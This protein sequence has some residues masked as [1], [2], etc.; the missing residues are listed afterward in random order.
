M[1]LTACIFSTDVSVT[2]AQNINQ[3]RQWLNK[4]VRK[5]KLEVPHLGRR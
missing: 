2:K 3:F 5:R 4:K 1:Y